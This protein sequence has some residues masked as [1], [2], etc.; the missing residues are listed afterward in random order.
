VGKIFCTSA[1]ASLMLVTVIFQAL[2]ALFGGVMYKKIR[3]H[4]VA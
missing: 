3:L 4:S 2:L 1:Q